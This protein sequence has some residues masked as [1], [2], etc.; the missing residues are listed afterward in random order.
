MNS[1][2]YSGG[3]ADLLF[4]VKL[5]VSILQNFASHSHFRTTHTRNQQQETRNQYTPVNNRV[6]FFIQRM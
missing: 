2:S 6:Y 3:Q 1:A 4:H 5:P